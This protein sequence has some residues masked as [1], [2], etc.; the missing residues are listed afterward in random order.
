MPKMK[1]FTDGATRSEADLVNQKKRIEII[2][3]RHRR[4]IAI[5]ANVTTPG[6]QMTGQT[7]PVRMSTYAADVVKQSKALSKITVFN[8]FSFL[9]SEGDA[10]GKQQFLCH[11][12]FLM[13]IFRY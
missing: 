11:C 5:V 4:N 1:I 9:L 10:N 13:A 7:H 3:Q 2:I 8:I 6:I 12:L